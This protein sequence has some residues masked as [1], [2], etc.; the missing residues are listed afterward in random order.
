MQAQ[1]WELCGRS[2]LGEYGPKDKDRCLDTIR[3]VS[4]AMGV[5]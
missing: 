1:R 2:Y 4:K 3:C 5:I